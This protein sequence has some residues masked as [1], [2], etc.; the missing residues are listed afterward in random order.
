M[1]INNIA[2]INNKT[3][4]KKAIGIC[5]ASLDHSIYGDYMKTEKNIAK[6]LNNEICDEYSK[7]EKKQIKNFF[8]LL[9]NNENGT[10]VYKHCDEGKFLVFGKEAKDIKALNSFILKTRELTIPD[11]DYKQAGNKEF[12]EGQMKSSLA[13]FQRNAMDYVYP[14]IN[15]LLRKSFDHD[16]N[17]TTLEIINNDP[18]SSKAKAI[19]ATVKTANGETQTTTLN[20][21]A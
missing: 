20:F 8:K 3:A 16:E 5:E 6:V 2:N 11:T 12:D 19:I 13:T 9:T 21:S 4:F 15:A 18:T 17:Q 10:V 1:K 14:K 7:E